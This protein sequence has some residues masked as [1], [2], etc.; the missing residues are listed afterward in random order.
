[1][2][3]QIKKVLLSL[4]AAGCALSVAACA[5]TKTLTKEEAEAQLDGFT[6]PDNITQEVGSEYAVP[7]LAVFGEGGVEYSASV[8]AS[9]R[10][11][12]SE[13]RRRKNQIGR[14]AGI[15][16]HVHRGV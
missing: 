7:S 1:M 2:N 12:R 11:E 15:Y 8:S 4:L 5:K 13:N 16:S 14:S 3:K 6:L 9:C 10:R